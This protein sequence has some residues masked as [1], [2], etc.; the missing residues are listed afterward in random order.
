M[1]KLFGTLALWGAL[2]F[3]LLQ[4][5]PTIIGY[6]SRNNYLLAIARPAA[7]GQFL[8]VAGAYILLT[9]AFVTS[10][11]SIAYVGMNSHPLLP[12]MYRL[13]AVWGGHEG[14]IL[15]WIIILNIW[16]VAFVTLQKKHPLMPL[17][18]AV[19]GIIDICFLL[20]LIFTSNPFLPATQL[21][22]GSDLNPLLQDPGFVIHPPMLYTGY[23]GFAVTFALT[24]AALL[25]GEL[26]HAWAAITRHY[27]VAA[28]CFL[29]FG[30]M[31]GS[32]WA[33]R[34]LGWGGFWFWDPVENASLLPWL[35]GTA[36][37]HVLIIAEKR[38]AAFN[39]AALLAL[40]CFSL[41]L[42][43]TFLVR[44]GVLVSAHTF[45]SDPS[46]G[47]FLLLLLAV[48]LTASLLVYLTRL[49]LSSSPLSTAFHFVSRESSLLINSGL[50]IIAMLTIL[51]GTIYP[52]IVDALHMDAISVGAPYF[53]MVM[54]PLILVLMAFMGIGPLCQWQQQDKRALLITLGKH[55]VISVIAASALLW[56]IADTLQLNALF[57][58]VLSLWVILSVL[59]SWRVKPGM[60]AGHLGFAILI[61]GILLSSLLSQ[62]TEVKIRP[63][64]AV[65]L[66][67][68]QFFFIGITGI[69]GSNYRGIQGEFDVVKKTHHVTTM[70]PEKRIYFVRDMVMTKVDIHPGVFRDLYL[71]LGEPLEDNYWSV[72]VYYKPFIRWIWAGS[73]IMIFGG[74]LS[75][76]GYRTG[77]KS[78]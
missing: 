24:Q 71:A 56:S 63:G 27:A 33:Y 75:I 28:W 4:S 26:N 53:N 5:F 51:L 54:A 13:T 64:N 41:S 29:T 58:L 49:K 48:I 70:K 3:S 1:L 77:R 2:L 66:G 34:V 45:A 14:S 36:L 21:L 15:L 17:T 9:I 50:L 8:F 67:P 68:Y 46:R 62:E 6:Y 65:T 16:T 37:F 23:V 22:T 72:R 25:R 57:S 11:F 69:K 76:I 10:D 39:Y 7:I 20:F 61:I 12:F 19:L 30:I 74:I 59:S 18:T 78:S 31:L 43:G 38:N 73:I 52:L 32:W 55:L 42:L 47:V 60:F 35:A 44:S 40:I